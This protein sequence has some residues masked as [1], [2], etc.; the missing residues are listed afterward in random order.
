MCRQPVLQA[1][2]T[3]MVEMYLNNE[4]VTAKDIQ[5]VFGISETTAFNV[6]K[7]VYEYAKT[8]DI[9]IYTPP[10]RKLVPVDLLFEAYGWDIQK[11]QQKVKMLQKLGGLKQ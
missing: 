6:V 9:K 1:D 7:F 11:L 3:S 4:A 5:K 2:S 10:T 8:K